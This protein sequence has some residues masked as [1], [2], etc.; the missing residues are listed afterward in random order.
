MSFEIQGLPINVKLAPDTPISRISFRFTFR[1]D[2]RLLQVSRPS[3]LYSSI[4]VGTASAA[5]TC[6]LRFTIDPGLE[7]DVVLGSEWKDACDAGCNFPLSLA[8]IPVYEDVDR[9]G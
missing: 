4:S 9:M 7:C 1:M 3:T 8:T 6:V 2:R 5:F